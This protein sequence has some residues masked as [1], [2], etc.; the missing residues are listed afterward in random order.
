M[1]DFYIQHEYGFA[2]FQLVLAMLGM[3]AT[4]KLSDFNEI[5][6]E[7]YAV[8]LGTLIQLLLIPLLAC[9]FIGL[10]SLPAGV[11]I[12]IALIAAIPGGTSSN[13]FT[14]FAHGNVALS[15]SITAI[16]TLA[17]LLTTPLILEFLVASY[18]PDDFVMPTVQIMKEIFFNLLLPLGI[19]MLVLHYFPVF[20]RHLSQWCIRGSVLGLI[21]I[22]VGASLAGRLD[23]EA[24]GLLN[25]ALVLSF[26]GLI[27][28]VGWLAPRALG[29]SVADSIAVEM[30]VVVRSVNL[31]IMLKVAMFPALIGE[32]LQLGNM[33]LFSLLLYGAVQMLL[34]LVLIPMRRSGV[35]KSSTKIASSQ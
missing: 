21:L 6:R 32:Q 1:A 31:G 18:M 9:V 20:A 10:L 22:F 25:V 16:T 27:V 5:V 30:E 34:G 19:G 7:P 23:V 29:L 26:V 15:I 3:G 24:F 35:S 14:H 17:C 11:A 4:L 12:G 33:A 28:I 13:I 8:I 2:V